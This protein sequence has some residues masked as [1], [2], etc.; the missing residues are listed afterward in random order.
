MSPSPQ[1]DEQVICDMGEQ[2]RALIR[3][4]YY[5]VSRKWRSIAKLPEGKT[6]I[7][8]L[9]EV[10]GRPEWAAAL[11]EGRA[12]DHYLRCYA[13]KQRELPLELFIA[14]RRWGG[15][16]YSQYW[17]REGNPY[18]WAVEE[19]LQKRTRAAEKEGL[20]KEEAL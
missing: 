20:R 16:C 3:A 1:V 2:A 12:G 5:Q 14:F 10:S 9:T 4:G 18:F 17:D 8:A 13:K 11:G 15:C 7:E 19:R 6:G